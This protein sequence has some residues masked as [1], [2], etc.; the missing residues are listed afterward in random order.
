MKEMLEGAEFQMEFG[1]YNAAYS[2]LEQL[3]GRE[4]HN[5]EVVQML[6]TALAE[7]GLRDEAIAKLKVAVALSPDRGH[8]KYMYLSQLVGD[9]HHIE[10]KND[11]AIRYAK[12]GIEILRRDIQN[13]SVDEALRDELR[14]DLCQALCGLVELLLSSDL[15]SDAAALATEATPLLIEAQQY[16]PESPEPHQVLASLLVEQGKSEEALVS[17]RK[18]LSL[19]YKPSSHQSNANGD[20]A[21]SEGD[22][23][24]G[25]GDELPS[26]EF[27]FE[28]A[29]L[30]LELEEDATC[31]V[32]IL[33][34]LLGENDA[35]LDVWFLLT[36]AHQGMG[37]LE[38]ALECLSS[39]EQLLKGMSSQ[40]QTRDGGEEGEF[41]E[42]WLSLKT[43]RGDVEECLKQVNEE[44]ES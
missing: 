30:V 25:C 15:N 7:M 33:E 42:Q 28:A 43:L 8:E 4:P 36:L 26:F 9:G 21:M 39:A 31:A 44:M 37:E 22:D 12:K 1:D 34:R 24:F 35:N 38:E 29:K 18:S 19:W 11:D 14:G 10:E 5:L 6:G 17:L 32:D 20:D 40:L 2:I 27:R 41:A 23:D 13:Q 3:H 16:Q